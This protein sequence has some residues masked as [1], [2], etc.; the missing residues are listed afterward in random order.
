MT[1]RVVV[2]DNRAK[3]ELKLSHLVV[4]QDGN[5]V[6]KI[7]LKDISHIIVN[8]DSFLLEEELVELEKFLLYNDIKALALQNA[9]RSLI[10]M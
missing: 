4:R 1:W 2:I 7:Y 6:Q 9:I 3:L 8:L 5:K 10:V